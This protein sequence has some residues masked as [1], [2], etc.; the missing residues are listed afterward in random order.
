MS[1]DLLWLKVHK[2]EGLEEI[3]RVS[4][5]VDFLGVAFLERPPLLSFPLRLFVS[6]SRFSHVPPP[7]S[8]KPFGSLIDTRGKAHSLPLYARKRCTVYWT[9]VHVVLKSTVKSHL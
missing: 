2:R 8:C 6:L 4:H 9:L 5:L 7:E 3:Q 1:F